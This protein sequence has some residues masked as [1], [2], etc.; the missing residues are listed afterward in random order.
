MVDM[1][2]RNLDVR[3][4]MTHMARAN[5]HH[6]PKGNTLMTPLV[7][8]IQD[9]NILI[10]HTLLIIFSQTALLPVVLLEDLVDQDEWL[11]RCRT[12]ILDLISA[13]VVN[14]HTH[15]LRL[16]PSRCPTPRHKSH[17]RVRHYSKVDI[18]EVVQ[19]RPPTQAAVHHP[20]NPHIQAISHTKPRV[21]EVER[22]QH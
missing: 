7:L 19:H 13:L 4:Q 5:I 3:T 17:D 1:A 2:G 10:D 11:L 20:K 18:M 21:R 16:R 9:A 12:T 15:G 8:S 14:N 22:Q 6:N